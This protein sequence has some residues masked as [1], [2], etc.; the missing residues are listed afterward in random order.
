M[1][2]ITPL[3]KFRRDR[4][5]TLRDFAKQVGVSEGQLSRIEREGTTSLGRA[6]SLA[7]KTGL[8]AE[9]FLRKETAA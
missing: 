5:L 9:V 4:K 8:A 6:L 1:V 7:E 2:E 3:R